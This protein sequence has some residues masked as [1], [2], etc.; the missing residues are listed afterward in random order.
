MSSEG[1]VDPRTN[2]HDEDNEVQA[3]VESSDH[4]LNGAGELDDED[5][6]LFGSDEEEAPTKPR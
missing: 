3:T 6:D 4:S 1:S 2:G 5:G